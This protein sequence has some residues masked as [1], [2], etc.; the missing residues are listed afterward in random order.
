MTAIAEE[1][2]RRLG[3]WYRADLQDPGQPLLALCEAFI[4]GLQPIEDVIRDT[5]THVGWGKI[6]DPDAAPAEWLPWLA[7]FVGVR[8]TDQIPE[9]ER[10]ALIKDT[11]GF[12]RGT[13]AA[14]RGAVQALLT[15]DKTVYFVERQGSAYGLSVSTLESETPE[16]DRATVNQITNP[17]A[18]TNIFGWGALVGSGG[19]IT[20]PAARITSDKRFGTACVAASANGFTSPP[21]NNVLQLFPN[22]SAR[23]VVVPGQKVRFRVSG[24]IAA[25]LAMVG[26]VR[27]DIG[28]ST[29]GAAF[30]TQVTGSLTPA[31]GNWQDLVFTVGGLDYT[32]APAT[33]AFAYGA[34]VALSG[35]GVNAI[36]TL[37]M[38]ADGGFMTVDQELPSVYADGDSAGW[39]WN[40]TPHASTSRRIA[41]TKVRDAALKQKPAGIVLTHTVIQGADYAALASTHTDYAD[42]ASTFTSYAEIPTNPT[43]Q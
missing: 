22:S 10:R 43:K 28:F 4:G 9:A 30:I 18:E 17:S 41:T 1:L 37:T 6:M 25:G 31:N 33:A 3:P 23:A 13:P 24:K 39:A 26:D 35:P 16:S 15:G 34:L 11:P 40:G 8:F 36:D 19:V 42:I 27:C 2:Y 21:G 5:D 7:Q 29:S 20:A 14:I 38:Y 32:V 12:R